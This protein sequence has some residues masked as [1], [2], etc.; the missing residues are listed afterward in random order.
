MNI[1]MDPVQGLVCQFSKLNNEDK[2]AFINEFLDVCGPDQK[3]QLQQKLPDF[4]FRDF[5]T[6]LPDEVLEMVLSY[7]DC[8]TLLRARKVSKLWQSR[9]S[10]LKCVWQNEARLLGGMRTSPDMS[11][12]DWMNL[13]AFAIRTRNKIKSSSAFGSLSVNEIIKGEAQVTSVCLVDDNVVLSLSNR[14]Y[15]NL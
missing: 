10:S 1:K 12:K 5:F 6:L 15:N 8:M 7:L 11:A 2:S 13:C 9:L 14:K 3:W 4:L